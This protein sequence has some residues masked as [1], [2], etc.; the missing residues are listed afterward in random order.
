RFSA[1]GISAVNFGPG[2]ALLAHSDDEHVPQQAIR[3]CLQT[4]RTWLG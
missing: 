3:D 2:D 1:L 4:L